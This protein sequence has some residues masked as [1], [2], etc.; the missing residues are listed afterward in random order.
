MPIHETYEDVLQNLEMSV[1]S[2]FR[3]N[4]T[5]TDYVA[6]RAYEAAYEHYRAE[7]R[8]HPAKPHGLTGLDATTFAAVEAICEFRLGRAPG[9]DPKGPPVK[10][11]TA[12]EIVTCLRRLA[13]SVKL[14]TARAGRQGYLNFVA[15][16]LP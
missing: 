15:H 1:V 7:Q 12:E 11:I 9:P 14:N 10:P 2:V 8:G 16:F 5:M 4:P 3:R 13:R 6:L